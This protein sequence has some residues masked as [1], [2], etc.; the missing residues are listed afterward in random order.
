[1]CAAKKKPA[2]HDQSL[3][4][5]LNGGDITPTAATLATKG[6]TL[7]FES[8]AVLLDMASKADAMKLPDAPR[9]GMSFIFG[10]YAV[11]KSVAT[12]SKKG[13]AL[14]P[15]KHGTACFESMLLPIDTGSALPLLV[16]QSMA[17]C[18]TCC[19][20]YAGWAVKRKST[21]VVAFDK[22][23]NGSGDDGVFIFSSSGSVFKKG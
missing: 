19:G 12:V 3:W 7:D 16:R 20:S 10:E 17:P 6:G 5:A 2:G 15:A 1:M 8:A 11:V 21:I 14:V 18:A 13:S 22:G 4:P 9:N 23:H